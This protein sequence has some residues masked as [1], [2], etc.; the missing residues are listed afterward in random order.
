MIFGG[1]G[2]FIAVVAGLP[3]LRSLLVFGCQSVGMN[4]ITL[5]YIMFCLYFIRVMLLMLVL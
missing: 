3:H 1:G 5:L 2:D 4:T